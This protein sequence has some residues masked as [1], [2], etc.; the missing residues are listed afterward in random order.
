MQTIS[1][2]RDEDASHSSYSDSRAGSALEDSTQNRRRF[3]SLDVL[4]KSHQS[5]MSN[6]IYDIP[7]RHRGKK[8]VKYSRKLEESINLALSY[9]VEYL[10]S[11]LFDMCRSHFYAY[12]GLIEKFSLI[13]TVHPLLK[14][15]EKENINSEKW[16]E[17]L[18]R[19]LVHNSDAIKQYNFIKRFVSFLNDLALHW[20]LINLYDYRILFEKNLEYLEFLDFRE[21]FKGIISLE[22]IWL[23]FSLSSY[24]MCSFANEYLKKL[25]ILL[26]FS[27]KKVYKAF[28]DSNRDVV[29]RFE[30]IQTYLASKNPILVKEYDFP[31][32][33][34]SPKPEYQALRIG[35]WNALF[36][37]Y[38]GLKEVLT[39]FE[40]IYREFLIEFLK[41][42][43]NTVTYLKQIY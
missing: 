23:S 13:A 18:V 3:S 16:K 10:E 37:K 30:S 29:T 19:Y 35:F 24:P 12:N 1:D 26:Q 33:R 15:L 38:D 7:E 42:S 31:K 39:E 2:Y 25:S 22:A 9:P 11:Q 5:G 41:H 8:I 21:L 17:M 36:G 27:L 43:F 40:V 34:K 4:K 28:M 14:L 20:N 32:P 6:G